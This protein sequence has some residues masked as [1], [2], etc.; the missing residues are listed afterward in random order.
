MADYSY[1]NESFEDY[2]EVDEF[3]YTQCDK[4]DEALKYEVTDD[5]DDMPI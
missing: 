1:D 5:D 4:V 3:D 2:N